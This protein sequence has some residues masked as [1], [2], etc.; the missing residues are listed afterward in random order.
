MY[1]YIYILKSVKVLQYYM[2]QDNRRF[3]KPVT[4][5]YTP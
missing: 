3:T 2:K 5:I 1:I 4:V